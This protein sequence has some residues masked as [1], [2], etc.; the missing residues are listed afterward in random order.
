MLQNVVVAVASNVAVA[1]FVGVVN[2][3]KLF[4]V[5]GGFFSRF[6]VVI[7]EIVEVAWPGKEEVLASIVLLLVLFVVVVKV[8][9]LFVVVVE[10]VVVGCLR[11]LMIVALIV[12]GWVV[13]VVLLKI[14]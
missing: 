10:M 14:A 3:V 11:M 9:V 7:A 1:R 13:V 4:F 2:V 6:P 5:D 12:I 8:S